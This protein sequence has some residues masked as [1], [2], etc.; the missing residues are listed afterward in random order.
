MRS[1]EQIITDA[2]GVTAFAQAISAPANLAQQWKRLDS[3]P[4]PYWK[5][6]V[7]AGL[8]TFEEM[9]EAAEK[10][11]PEPQEGLAA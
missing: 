9:A 6:V 1:H 10:R 3:I 4:A 5:A 2:G 8:A 11:R 7:V